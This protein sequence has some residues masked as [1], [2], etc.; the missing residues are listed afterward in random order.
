[1]KRKSAIV[2]D[3]FDWEYVL[4]RIN[5]VDGP[6]EDVDYL[7]GADAQVVVT[8]LDAIEPDVDYDKPISQFKSI[9]EE[10]T[11]TPKW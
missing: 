4:I 5:G 6:L 10:G 8:A 7:S 3:E 1:M 9:V 2:T 11:N